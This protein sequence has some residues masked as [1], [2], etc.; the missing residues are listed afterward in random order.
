MSTSPIVQSAARVGGFSSQAATHPGRRTHNEDAYLNRPDLGLW[1]VAD[2]AG[3]HQSGEI[4]SSKVVTLLGGIE[5]GLPAAQ[6]LNEVRS[7]LEAAHAELQA[8][9][10]RRGDD[11]VMATTVVIAVVRDDHFA[12]LWVGD[13]P[14]YLLRGK[15]IMKITREHSLVQEMVDRG[16]IS[17]SEAEGHPQAN[18]ITRAVGADSDTVE[19]EKRTGRLL[20]GD[21]LLL[22]SDG[23][24][25]TIPDE[26]LAELSADHPPAL[27]ERLVNAA[28]EARVSDN[29][30]AVVIEFDGLANPVGSATSDST[31][32]AEDPPTENDDTVQ[33]PPPV[34]P[35]SASAPSVQEAEVLAANGAM[36]STPPTELGSPVVVNAEDPGA[37]AVHVNETAPAGEENARTVEDESVRQ[38][39]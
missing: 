6:V 23:L 31:A 16:V 12:C 21:R 24:S 5:A 17:S 13:S 25:K 35:V 10:A 22:C 2:G 20:P 14:C 37:V 28:L 27:A 38:K 3:G 34:S 30:T 8:E 4:A 26:Q 11:V 9:A 19:L 1:A 18:V 39:A 36:A 33:A 15:A 7:R 32:Q 29:V